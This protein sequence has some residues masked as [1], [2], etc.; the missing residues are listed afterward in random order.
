MAKTGAKPNLDRK[1]FHFSSCL[2]VY[3]PHL[4]LLPNFFLPSPTTATITNNCYQILQITGKPERMGAAA[5]NR[6]PASGRKRKHDSTASSSS[7]ANYPT[8]DDELP[9]TPTKK[10]KLK[11]EGEKRLR[12]YT[13]KHTILIPI[14]PHF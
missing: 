1:S 12:R 3:G 2:A 6:T 8:Y 11:Q 5:D 14:E 13:I 10:R 7:A 4:L 9:S